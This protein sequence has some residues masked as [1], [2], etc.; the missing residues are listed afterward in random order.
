MLGRGKQVVFNIGVL[1]AL[2]TLKP[3]VELEAVLKV[4][5]KRFPTALFSINQLALELGHE[6]GTKINR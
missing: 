3:L 5:E 6:L 4:L 1:G 2:L